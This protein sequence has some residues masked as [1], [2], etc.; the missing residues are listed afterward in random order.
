M[1]WAR[2]LPSGRWQGGY[3]DSSGR[4][5]TAGKGSWARKEDALDAAREQE[6]KVKR[7]E[8]IDP[9]LALTPFDEWAWEWHRGRHKLG[10]VA[11]RRDESLLRLHVI[12]RDLNPW[13]FGD[14]PIEAIQPADVAGWVNT[15]VSAGYKPRTV[16]PCFGLFS[17]VMRRAVAAKM[18]HE[19]PVT[20]GLVDL[21]E[22]KPKR[23]RFLT[24]KEVE[25]LA[26]AHPPFYRP[27][28]YTLAYTG[29]R[30]QEAAG[31]LR[32]NLDLDGARLHV[33]KVQERGSGEL[34]AFP[35]ED[36]SRRS[37]SLN[38]RLVEMLRFHLAG[39]PDS[40]LVFPSR[41]GKMLNPSNF[42]RVW[43]RASSRARLEPLSPHDLRHTHVSWLIAAE[44]PDF[45][46]VKRCGW[47]DSRMLYTVYGHLM[48]GH[49][50][51]LARGLDSLGTG[52]SAAHMPRDA[53][54]ERS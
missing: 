15:L 1:A 6:R 13:G 25:R 18:L 22:L 36:A 7:R 33:R 51:D 16:H 3:R 39:A 35:K 40:P 48:P 8:W 26:L 32:T 37:V 24:P 29:L 52:D 2:K 30:W 42:R 28:V 53:A 31:L 44:W 41:K 14:T 49:D 21:P 23:E 12:G 46:I 20:P 11:R 10:D 54:H 45:K 34:K 17:A 47:R 5:R 38:P 43:A 19:S 4:K 50:E 9:E 27:L